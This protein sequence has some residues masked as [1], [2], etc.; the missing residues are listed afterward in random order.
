M[1]KRILHLTDLHISGPNSIT[2]N[3]RKNR[4]K[5]YVDEL[6]EEFSKSACS[7]DLDFLFI[8]GDF[9]DRGRV[10]NFEY[11]K[12]VVDYIIKKFKI[13]DGK[14][15]FCIGNHDLVRDEE[16]KGNSVSAIQDY[17][18]F[19]S[20]YN[21][22]KNSVLINNDRASVF[23]AGSDFVLVFDAVSNTG[24]T[25]RPAGEL[26]VDFIDLI[27]S[28]LV[29]ETV[30]SDS[31]LFI[32]SHYPVVQS[33]KSLLDY[34]EGDW[35]GRHIWKSGYP[36]KE[37]I[38][39]IRGRLDG[40]TIWFFGDAH[41][42]DF[43]QDQ[44]RPGVLYTMTG[45]FGGKYASTLSDTRVYNQYHQATVLEIAESEIRQTIFSFGPEGF[46]F[47]PHIGKWTHICNAIQV[48]SKNGTI[49][50]EPESNDFVVVT[51]KA[52]EDEIY[53][54]ILN[55][56]LYKFGKFI[57]S[58]KNVS[59]GW[60]SINNLFSNTLLFANS[61]ESIVRYLKKNI[62]L[63]AEIEL[64]VGCGFWGGILAS[65]VS[66]RTGIRS[67]TISSFVSDID[68]CAYEESI[69]FL[70]SQPTKFDKI[71]RIVVFTDVISS[72]ETLLSI[73][74]KIETTMAR[75]FDWLAVTI[76]VDSNNLSADFKI[77]YQICASLCTKLKMPVIKRDLLPDDDIDPP[78]LDLTIK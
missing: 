12:V 8:T 78:R 25:D 67:H 77:G 40:K 69:E 50:A 64:F 27:A 59:L 65:N 74:S 3:L 68:H 62:P 26:D 51:G 20:E 36:L 4:Y 45:Q 21:H 14:T 9:V 24:G 39:K 30:P 31:D 29:R 46:T 63:D 61:I 70:I 5:E 66:V 56:G 75:T 2:E 19:A 47:N 1:T 52:I 54:E 10:E 11:V 22:G 73:K 41:I 35:T 57:T 38:S 58:E 60:V 16:R 55:E 32:L 6:H 37:R 76:L 49:I 48:P 17:T 72:G 44:D 43:F 53:N 28:E 42:P 13:A 34:E 18:K 71:K 23:Q 7:G 15:F 33:K